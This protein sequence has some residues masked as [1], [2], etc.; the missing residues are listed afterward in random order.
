MRAGRAEG[1]RRCEEVVQ[2][3]ERPAR[4]RALAPSRRLLPPPVL[5]LLPRFPATV[6]PERPVRNSRQLGRGARD[7]HVQTG[8]DR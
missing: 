7:A 2:V 3:S 5:C 4:Q 6:G 8:P 1:V